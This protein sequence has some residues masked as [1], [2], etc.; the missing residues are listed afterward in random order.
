MHHA[1]LTKTNFV[2]GRVNIDIDFAG[3]QIQKQ[4][5]GRVTA[6]IHH[7]AI[8]LAHRM[9]DDFIFDHAAVDVK[10]LKISLATRKRRQADPAP[11]SHAGTLKINLECIFNKLFTANSTNT[12]AATFGISGSAPLM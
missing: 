12:A 1:V 11:K 5:K 7:I 10:I 6:V 8:G 3:G 4:D 2:F 9:A